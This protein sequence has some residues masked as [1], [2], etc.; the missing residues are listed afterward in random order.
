MIWLGGGMAQ[1]DTFDPK[2]IGN[3]KVNQAGSEYASIPT[4]VTGVRVCEHLANCAGVMDRMTAIRT[5][6][7]DVIDEHGAAV[8]R[9]HTGRPTSGTIQ[10][11]SI[12]AIIAKEMGD[13]PDQLPP[14]M[15]IGYPSIARDPGFLDLNMDI[16]M[17]LTPN[18]A[19]LEFHAPP[20][21]LINNKIVANPC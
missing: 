2:K 14:Y 16:S 19:P 20:S 18:P 11:P 21:F 1:I 7:H 9:V 3:S 8:I 12:G 17:S 5:V 13:T 6:H 10:Y 4:T 15:V